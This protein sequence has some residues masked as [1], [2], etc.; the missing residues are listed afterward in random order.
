MGIDRIGKFSIN[1]TNISLLQRPLTIKE[2]IKYLFT[3]YD[4]SSKFIV[5]QTIWRREVG[6][7]GGK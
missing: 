6:G 4:G 7:G 5:S 2:V 1:T 3:G